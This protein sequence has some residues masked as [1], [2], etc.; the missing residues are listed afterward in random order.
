M[1]RPL[2]NFCKASEILRD[3]CCGKQGKGKLSHINA[4]SDSLDFIKFM[5]QTVQ[6]VDWQFNNNVAKQVDE[7]RHIIK[8]IFKTII[9]CGQQSIGLRGHRDD[10]GSLADNKGIFLA[11]L[12]F[13]CDAGD[14]VLQSYID[15][16]SSRATYTSKTIQNEVI[17]TC[18][19]HILEK[20]LTEVRK[21]GYFSII[22]DEATDSSNNEQLSLV[23]RFVDK[24]INVREEFLAFFECTSGVTGEALAEDTL[25][26]LEKDWQLNMQMFC[27]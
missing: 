19:D 26:K 6:P 17:K 22:G 3:H 18:G 23:I 10:S 24:D 5:E 25:G 7:N 2:I 9:F 13:R 8:S 21:A 4:V 20:L 11:L 12:K 14:H 27:G 16:A 1:S 15:R